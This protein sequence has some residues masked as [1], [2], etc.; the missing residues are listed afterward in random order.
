MAMNIRATPNKGPVP[1]GFPILVNEAMQIIEPAFAYLLDVATISGRSTSDK[2]VRTYSEHL[3]D[4]FDTLEQMG[5]SWNKVTRVT[6]AAYRNRHQE[7]PS[8][9]TKRPYA[10]STI[11]ARVGAVCRFYT[12]AQQ[13]GLVDQV[14]F[15][16]V[17]LRRWQRY[18]PFSSH[19]ETVNEMTLRAYE[20]QRRALLDDEIHRL[21]ANLK[22]PY[23]LMT[24][25]ALNTG[26]RR[27]EICALKLADILPHIRQRGSSYK[28]VAIPLKI[29]KGGR[30]RNAYAPLWLLDDT[31][32]YINEVREPLTRELAR[33]HPFYRTG[34]ALF[35]GM[36]GQPIKPNRMSD[37]F[38]TAFRAEEIVADLHCLRHTYAIRSLHAL[39]KAHKDGKDINVM[40]YLRHLMGHASIATTDRYLNRW[41]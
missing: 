21:K 1:T 2:T 16:K 26:M 37:A 32:R 31:E 29:T 3:L 39:T 23:K 14:P 11:N 15:N 6:L 19:Q 22:Q 40:L 18:Q 25:W 17:E 10:T 8:P 5:I 34:D 7:K 38:S 35:L 41:N 24:D 20:K 33:R 27:M 30:P 12:W 4:W 13:E 9:G 36:R 28:L